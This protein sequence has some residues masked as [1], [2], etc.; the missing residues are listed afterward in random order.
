MQD[1]NG[2]PGLGTRVIAERRTAAGDH[3]QATGRAQESGNSVGKRRTQLDF[4]Y[5]GDGRCEV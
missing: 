5:C 4:G 3:H 2:V 1:H